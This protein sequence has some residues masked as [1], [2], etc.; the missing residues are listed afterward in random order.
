[1]N[2]IY[3]EIVDVFPEPEPLLGKVRI[4]RAVRTISLDLVA[5]AKPGDKVLVCDGVAIGKVEESAAKET[6]HVP[7]DS[8]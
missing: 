7:R 5:N 4:G 6:D 8:G 2:L 1:M 3:G